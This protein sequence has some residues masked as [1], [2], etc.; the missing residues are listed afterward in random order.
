M[1]VTKWGSNNVILGTNR[2][3]SDTLKYI[4]M[5]MQPKSTCNWKYNWNYKLSF[6]KN[7]RR[8]FYTTELSFCAKPRSGAGGP[9][10]VCIVLIFI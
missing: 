6:D 7:N 3:A 8:K 5:T 9:C 4:E 2:Q 10:Q 1:H